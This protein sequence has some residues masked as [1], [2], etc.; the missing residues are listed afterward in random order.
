ME[1][2]K[3]TLMTGFIIATGEPP[4][5]R[6]ALTLPT[7]AG[8]TAEWLENISIYDLWYRASRNEI[9]ASIYCKQ[10]TRRFY[11][12]T[13]LMLREPRATG[14]YSTEDLIAKGLIG[15]YGWRK[16][17]KQRKIMEVFYAIWK[18]RSV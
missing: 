18:R 10:Y 5:T 15:V 12:A 11:D 8:Y 4:E 3:A 17:R 6:P 9:E 13:W 14:C 16:V 2:G 1:S 7:R